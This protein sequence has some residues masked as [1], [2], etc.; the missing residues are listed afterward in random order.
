MKDMWPDICFSVS[1]DTNETH[2]IDARMLDKK[3]HPVSVED[4]NGHHPLL[5]RARSSRSAYCHRVCSNA[6]MENSYLNALNPHAVNATHPCP[7]MYGLGPTWLIGRFS[8]LDDATSCKRQAPGMPICLT[9]WTT[10]N[11]LS[12]NTCNSSCHFLLTC[13]V[14]LLLYASLSAPS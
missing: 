12:D 9:R 5:S 8:P 2:L 11:P 1:R 6:I 3:G 10:R 13:S 4:V 14:Q 7:R